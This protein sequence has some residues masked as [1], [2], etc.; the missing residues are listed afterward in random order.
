MRKLTSD[1]DQKF[2]HLIAN[3]RQFTGIITSVEEVTDEKDLKLDFGADSLDIVE[4]VMEVE[5]EF[6]VHIPDDIAESVVTVGD[7]LEAL[8]SSLK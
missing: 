7:A 4:L 2:R 5:K 6:E 1:Q 8:Q 3:F